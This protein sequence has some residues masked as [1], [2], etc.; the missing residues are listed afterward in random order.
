MTRSRF[1]WALLATVCTVSFSAHVAPAASVAYADM[2]D[3]IIPG[4]LPPGAGELLSGTDTFTDM[5]FPLGQTDPITGALMPDTALG[6]LT[7][8]YY[9]LNEL[10]STGQMAIDA[11]QAAEQARRQAEARRAELA[12]RGQLGSDMPYADLFNAA[13]AAHN[14][15]PRMLAAVAAVE[16]NFADDVVSCRRASSAGA[17]GLM[18]LMPPVAASYGVNP[19]VPA[20]AIDGAARMLRGL[21]QRYGSFDVAFAAYN[22]GPGT[23]DRAGKIV[24]AAARGYVDKVNRYWDEYRT[25]YPDGL[26]APQTVAS[27]SGNLC[28]KK[29]GAI[30]VACH[31]APQVDALVNAAA[32]QGMRLTGGGYRSGAEQVRMF[33]QRYTTSPVSNSTRTWN[34]V[35]YY[36]KPGNA[37]LATPGK[38]LHERGEA[39]D[40]NCDGSLIVSKSNKCFLWLSRNAATYGLYNYPVEAWHWSTTGG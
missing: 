34:G 24:P 37:P 22:V 40:F 13:G 14:L 11:L 20:E 30:T 3:P 7:D 9:V 10:A 19:C 1:A 23:V 12:R 18:Q 2:N 39:I 5:H 32:S 35:T 8:Q 29:V 31:I 26:G 4:G 28:L 36:L 6:A 27:P 16:S 15:D 33:Q 38:S 17:L 21:W 25:R